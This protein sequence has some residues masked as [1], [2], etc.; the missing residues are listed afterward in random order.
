MEFFVGLLQATM[1]MIQAYNLYRDSEGE[2]C[3]ARA[4]K[5]E[6]ANEVIQLRAKLTFLMSG[7]DS[8]KLEH[9]IN[10]G[11]INNKDEEIA[12]LRR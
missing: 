9:D 8:L 10:S 4:E 5:N 2:W 1:N 6:V 12:R 11:V 3:R 7:H